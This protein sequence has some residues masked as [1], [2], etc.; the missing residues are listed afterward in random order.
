MENKLEMNSDGINLYLTVF[1]RGHKK[2]LIALGLLLLVVVSSFLY[3]A[4]HDAKNVTTTNGLLMMVLLLVFMWFP[5]KYFLWNLYGIE[6]LIINTAT[7]S[8][9][10]D[11]GWFKT[12]LETIEFNSLSVDLDEMRLDGKQY[13]G[14]LYFI[15]FDPKT[16]LPEI[17]HSTTAFFTMDQILEIQV[18]IASLFETS[19][20]EERGFIPYS[21]N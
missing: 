11:Y 16:K 17:I 14:Q 8:Y 12:N 15:D 4:V 2:G 21:L 9:S 13:L 6:Y 1:V 10:H 5:V 18:G 19:F 20:N 3:L 7:I